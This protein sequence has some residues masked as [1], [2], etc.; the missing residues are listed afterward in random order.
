MAVIHG[1]KADVFLN[2]YNAGD[3]FNSVTSQATKELNEAT[4]LNNNGYKAHHARMRDATFTMNGFFDAS[5][6]VDFATNTALDPDTGDYALN[7]MIQGGVVGGSD[8]VVLHAPGGANSVGDIIFGAKG[9]ATTYGLEGSSSELLG[10]SV[11]FTSCCG[12]ERCVLAKPL[13]TATNTF[14]GT[15]I[16]N[17][18]STT[19]GGSAYLMVTDWT[20]GSLPVL[21]EHS[22]D[23]ISWSTLGSFAAVGADHAF[24]RI[25][26]SG[27]V[28]RYVRASAA[29]TYVAT[30][31]V[32][33]HRN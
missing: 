4:T 8:D 9:A 15:Q 20:S 19:K 6:A 23:G 17:T 28:N 18:A 11:E 29:G 1:S 10:A 7:A 3:W 16:D 24:E 33:I 21:I 26:F 5:N 31:L 12:R 32:A 13:A 30:F 25:T 22:A 2:G 14:T 27:T